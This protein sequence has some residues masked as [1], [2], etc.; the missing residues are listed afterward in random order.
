MG[1]GGKLGQIEPL[2]L[3]SRINIAL[4]IRW[5]SPN[6]WGKVLV[7]LVAHL[8]LNLLVVVLCWHGNQ[9]QSQPTSEQATPSSTAVAAMPATS[10]S[11]PTKRPLRF[12]VTDLGT[13]WGRESRVHKPM[14]GGVEI[15]S[16]SGQ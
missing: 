7:G 16:A 9:G 1:Q 4:A 15:V 8:A 14:L 13:L 12:A 3:F 5:K 6:L 10:T 11:N 2:P